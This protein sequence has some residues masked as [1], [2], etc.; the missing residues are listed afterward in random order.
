[1]KSYKKWYM[2]FAAVFLVTCLILMSFNYVVDPFGV[3]GDNFLKMYNYDISKNGRIAKI[4]YL[5]RNYEMF[6]SYIVGGSKS[7][8][9]LPETAEKYYPGS[10]FYNLNMIGGRFYDY[11]HT[12]YYLINKYNAKNIILQISQLELNIPKTATTPIMMLNGKLFSDYPVKFYFK[13]LMQNPTYSIEKL[14]EYRKWTKKYEEE[15]F[16]QSYNGAYNR[17]K[18]ERLISKRPNDIFGDKSRFPENSP[19][20]KGTAIKINL[21]SLQRIKDFCE[22]K[23]V[24]LL[25]ITAPTYITEL[26][27]FPIDDFAKYMKD[28]SKIT[29]YWNFSGY[30]SI[31]TEMTNFYDDNHFRVLVGDMMLARIFGDTSVEIPADFGKLITPENANTEI[32]SALNLD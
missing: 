5:D 10:K 9:L 18:E 8:S 16:Y 20:I 31:N 30:N 7:G 17:T 26:E 32:N 28:I 27:T 19:K 2:A 13:F 29:P 6:N 22:Q 15:F 24:N 11:E 3:F 25:V 14:L 4:S 21:E 1:M 12:I 23:G